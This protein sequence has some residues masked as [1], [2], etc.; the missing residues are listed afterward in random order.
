M[1]F[2][3]TGTFIR[4]DGTFTGPTVFQQERDASIDMLALNL[5]TEAQDMSDGLTNCVTRDGQSPPTANIPMATFI[6]TGLG[7]GT[8]R[9]TSINLGQVQDSAVINAGTFGGTANALTASLSPAITAYATRMRIIGT[10]AAS[11]TAAATLAL[12]GITS[13][14]AI[15]KKLASGLVAIS[16][17][18]WI[19]GQTISFTYDGTFWVLDDKPEWQSGAALTSAATIDLSTATG[20][21][22]SVSGSTGPITS[23]GTLPAGTTRILR[24]ASTPTLTHNATSLILPSGANIV[25]AAGDVA[26]FTSEGGGNWRCTNYMRATGGSVIPGGIQWSS[27]SAD[28]APAVA[29]RGYLCDT[30]SAAFTLTLPAAPAV[31][32]AVYFADAAGTFNTNALTIGRNSLV[33]MGLAQNMTVNTQYAAAG[34]IY[35][36]VTNGWRLV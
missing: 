7:P 18:E 6:L 36:G 1:P 14:P 28:P 19:A 13:P 12:N 21:Y 11:V 23:L 17:G 32:D 3:G 4:T 33:I 27:I 24:F 8:G 2:N 20:E 26:L 29:G 16:G 30:S 15:R 10:A 35:Q 22:C 9:L 34:L 5:D 31:G 25:A